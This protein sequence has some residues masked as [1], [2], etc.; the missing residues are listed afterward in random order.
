MASYLRAPLY[1]HV[2][3]RRRA[4]TYAHRR[5]RRHTMRCVRVANCGCCSPA[6]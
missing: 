2:D 6:S 3:A 5:E 1:V 4:V